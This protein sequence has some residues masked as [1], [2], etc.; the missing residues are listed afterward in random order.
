[1]SST[2]PFELFSE[3]GWYLRLTSRARAWKRIDGFILLTC[4]QAEYVI[5]SEPGAKVG[6]YLAR[7][8][9]IS[10][11]FRGGAVLWGL[12][13]CGGANGSLGGKKWSSRTSFIC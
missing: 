6:E 12:R 3:A 9:A 1:M 11:V 13:L 10:S 4:F 5:P 2:T 7:E 8:S